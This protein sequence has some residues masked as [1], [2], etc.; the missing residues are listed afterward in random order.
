MP[1]KR[2]KELS[3][4]EVKRIARPGLHAVGGVA[5]LHLRVTDSGARN[6]ILRT[7]IGDKRRDI[8]LGGF[9]DVT[10]AQARE[11]AR[12]VKETIW[13]GQDPIAERRAAEAALK[14][15]Q[16]KQLTFAQA[17]ERSHKAKAQEFRTAKHAKQWYASLENHVFPK[18][19]EMPVAEIEM[20]HVLEVLEP[21][22]TAKPETAAK[23]RQRIETVLTWAT[24]SGYRAGD[25]PARWQGN[26]KE[27]LPNV[28]KIHRTEH[29]PALHWRRIP[30]FMEAL[31]S[32]EGMG[33]RALEF[34]ILTASRSGEVRKATWREID[35]R[36]KLWTV[37]GNRTKTGKPHRVPLS[38]AALA[39]LDALP[40]Y[41]GSEY[42]FPAVRGGALS[43][44]TI[45][46]VTRRMHKSNVQAGGE[47]WTDP[48]TGRVVV[49]HGFRSSFKDWCR[50]R[51]AYPD[52]VSELALAHVNSDATR[53]AYARDE[54]LP[55]RER[56]MAD[57]SRFCRHG[58]QGGDVV[59]IREAN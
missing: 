8:G 33:A 42:V 59:G 47:G 56:L 49:P 4:V 20:P 21:I 37:P 48:Q 44:M 17:V 6:W 45:S 12:Q 32:V 54:L 3:A 27:V 43:D 2:A 46:A 16:A 30:E 26:L 39:V 35:K 9:P 11:R 57:W 29:W 28:S 55:Q 22:W 7:K 25:N 18:L 31:Q 24:V 40:R 50:S 36:D 5:G 34:T 10:L 13:Q 19:G 58:E 51:T 53:A 14:A 41:K 23:V 1:P 15:H 52:E 38:D